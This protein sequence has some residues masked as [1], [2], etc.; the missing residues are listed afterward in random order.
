M[1]KGIKIPC[2]DAED[3]MGSIELILDAASV[4][5]GTPIIN[6]EIRLGGLMISCWLDDLKRAIRQLEPE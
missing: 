1:L 5:E 2:W 4:E 3:A 6:I